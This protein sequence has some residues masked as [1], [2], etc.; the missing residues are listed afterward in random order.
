MKNILLIPSVLF[1]LA[2]STLSFAGCNAIGGPLT[3]NGKDIVVNNDTPV[4][5]LLATFSLGSMQTYSCDNNNTNNMTTGGKIYGEFATSINGI[6]VY[7]TNI[8]GIGYSLGVQSMCGDVYFPATGW[9]NNLNNISV[10]W[11][12]HTWNRIN[13]NF[14]VRI[15][16]IGPTE[17]GTVAKKQ[18][19][20]TILSYNNTNIWAKENPV[21]LNAFDVKTVGNNN[22]DGNNSNQG[23]NNGNQGGN[24]S[25][26]GNNNGHQGG[27]NG[28]QGSNHNGYPG[29]NNGNQG[30]N[31][32][33]YP[34]GNNGNQ[35]NNNNSYPGGNNGNQGSNH[36]GYPGGN[37]GNQGN[38]NSG[39]P[40]GNNGNQGSNHNGYPGGNNSNQNNN[41]NQWDNNNQDNGRNHVWPNGGNNNP[42]SNN[43]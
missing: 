24:N 14:D 23:N 7:K 27:N 20:A 10:C 31:H 9:K 43:F 32:N 13:H 37:N 6:R 40:G 19:G 26:Q 11:H 25:N 30:S 2:Y 42:N 1:N 34:G 39:Y 33:G 21:F 28:N 8:A 17:S 35:G 12:S 4:G 36:N 22:Q 41:N 16:K 3:I 29:S 15:Y 5:T 38:N 18:I